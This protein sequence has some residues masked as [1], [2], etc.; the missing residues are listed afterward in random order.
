MTK[1]KGYIYLL[2]MCDTLKRIIYKV[3]KSI[4]FYNRFKN[5]NYAE[6]ITFIISDDINNDEKQIIK[7]F[8]ECCKLDTGK[9]FFIAKDDFYVTK[10]FLDYFVN[11]NNN[12][13]I[14]NNNLVDNIIIENIVDN[15]IIENIVVNVKENIVVNAVNNVIIENVVNDTIN[16]NNN[17]MADRT[18][19][20]CNKIFIYPSELK[21]HFKNTIF[22]KKNAEDI[23][24]FFIQIKLNKQ[25]QNKNKKYKCKN[26][27]TIFVQKCS[28]TRHINISKCNTEYHERKTQIELLQKQISKLNYKNIKTK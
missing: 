4:N 11:K 19:T 2:K 23:K 1:I 24:Q 6:I 26:C 9:E 20:K 21:K 14:E 3:G 16:E 5:Y 10:I 7:I 28:L 17:K 12:N 15:N 22:C 8:N 13:I 25:E 27:N 18:C